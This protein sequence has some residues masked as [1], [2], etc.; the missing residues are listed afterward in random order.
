MV[1]GTLLLHLLFL[2]DNGEDIHPLH[3]AIHKAENLGDFTCTTEID[4]YFKA[5]VLLFLENYLYFCR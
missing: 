2:H 3:L 4:N 1:E 5:I